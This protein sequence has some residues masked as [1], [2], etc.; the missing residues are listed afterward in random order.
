MRRS[1]AATSSS[2]K[3]LSSDSIGTWCSTSPKARARR[4]GDALR[5][6]VG[7]DEL[8]VRALERA[9]LLHQPVVLGVRDLRVVEHVVAVVVLCDL[10]AQ[11]GCARRGRRGHDTA[12]RRSRSTAM[13]CGVS[14]LPR[15]SCSTPCSRS[16]R[17]R[18]VITSSSNACGGAFGP[19]S[20]ANSDRPP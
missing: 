17:L 1:K 16:L 8:G 7:G 2:L 9:Q 19:G 12:L 14:G 5:R 6:G 11:L 15:S 4:T 20:T 18:A 3:A 10:R 13:R